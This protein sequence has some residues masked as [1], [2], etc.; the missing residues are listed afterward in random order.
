MDELIKYDATN[1]SIRVAYGVPGRSS[2][3]ALKIPIAMNVFRELMSM[4]PPVEINISFSWTVEKIPMFYKLT[5]IEVHAELQK[6]SPVKLEWIKPYLVN[7]WQ[8]VS[9]THAM[10]LR[11]EMKHFLTQFM[12]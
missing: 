6:P 3:Y 5:H 10:Q 11:K 9:T 4:L 2:S 7:C 1:T 12:S 8:I